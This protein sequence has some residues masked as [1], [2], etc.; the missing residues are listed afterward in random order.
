MEHAQE[1][2]KLYSDGNITREEYIKLLSEYSYRIRMGNFQMAKE[3]CAAGAC[4]SMAEARRIVESGAFNK[5]MKKLQHKK[6]EKE[7]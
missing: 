5:V 4:C 3:L 2:H 7:A 1:I 6:N